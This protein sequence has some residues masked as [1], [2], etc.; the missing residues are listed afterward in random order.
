MGQKHLLEV[1]GTC[2]DTSPSGLE[3]LAS[4]PNPAGGPAPGPRTI[5]C[6]LSGRKGNVIT[7]LKSLRVE[8]FCAFLYLNALMKVSS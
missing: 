6:R 4:T 8:A 3:I 7:F 1:T 2:K 5:P